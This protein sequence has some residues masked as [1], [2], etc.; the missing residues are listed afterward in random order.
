MPAD[1]PDYYKHLASTPPDPVEKPAPVSNP[2]RGMPIP[3]ERTR[4]VEHIQPA[5]GDMYT[6]D[7]FTIPLPEDWTD[8]TIYTLT[9]PVTDGV[10]HNITINKQTEIGI[11][12]LLEFAE[13]QIQSLVTELASCQLLLKEPCQLANGLAAYRAIFVWWPAED[14]QLFQEQ[15]YVL[16]RDTGFT[17]TASFSKKTR[18]TLGPEIERTMLSFQPY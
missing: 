8:K 5:L 7:S 13:W 15:V 3:T 14:L 4:E 2:Y 1:I 6:A 12:E 18:K 10:Q 11:D 9:G 16:Y 17:L